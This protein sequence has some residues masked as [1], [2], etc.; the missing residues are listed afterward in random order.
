MT[1][2]TPPIKIYNTATDGPPPTAQ[3]TWSDDSFTISPPNVNAA[4]IR[5]EPIPLESEAGGYRTATAY[6]VAMKNI[7]NEPTI[8]PPGW[9]VDALATLEA[10][11][12]SI[13]A[14][15]KAEIARK[16]AEIEALRAKLDTIG[17][18]MKV[19][20]DAL[21][22]RSGGLTAAW[23]VKVPHNLSPEEYEEMLANLMRNPEEHDNG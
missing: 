12:V 7:Y 15:L 23:S 22:P 9:T 16:D 14:P 5:R 8:L 10:F 18:H 21:V 3:A 2:E 1:D 19:S 17:P 6:P 20:P 11:K 4:S 13:E